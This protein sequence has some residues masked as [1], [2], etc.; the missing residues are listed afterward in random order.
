MLYW[1]LLFGGLGITVVYVLVG[2][3]LE[4]IFGA[5][6]GI[7]NPLLIFSSLTIVGG[8]GVLLSKYTSISEWVVFAIAICIGIIGYIFVYFFLVVPIA[9]ADTSTTYSVRE[10]EGSIA[11]VITSVP[12]EGYGE[13]IVTTISGT[14]NFS[15]KSL[16]GTPIP[17][18]VRVV[19][20]RAEP[21]HFVVTHF[22]EAESEVGQTF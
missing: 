10:L 21:D 13:V 6:D 2:D 17:R 3:M 5:L 14:V 19:V 15:A 9:K 8:A 20:V 12:P 16:D 7:F 18:G 1:W 4:G 11:E 22:E